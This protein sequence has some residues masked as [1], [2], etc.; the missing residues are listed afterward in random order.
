MT[1]YTVKQLAAM[2]G[3]S[4]RTLHHYDRIGLLRPAQVGA[5]RYRYYRRDELL[6]LQQILIHRELGFSLAEI[7]AVLDAPGYDRIGTLRQQRERIVAATKRYAEIIRTIDRTIA[8]LTGE[9]TMNDAELYHGV[10]SPQKQAEYEAWLRERHGD[11]IDADLARSRETWKAMQE[12][13]HAAHMADLAEIEHGLA[14]GLRRGIPAESSAHDALLERHW[15]WVERGWARALTPE[16]YAG[17]ADLYLS[18]PDFVARYE[19]LAPGFAQY[20][21]ATMKAFAA[22]GK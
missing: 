6:R 12:G 7:A 15:R 22:R 19:T 8:N 16:A 9:I 21:A 3:V 4:V 1:R 5:N 2:A 10:V 20:L 11:R 18:H 17:L 14:E 13:E